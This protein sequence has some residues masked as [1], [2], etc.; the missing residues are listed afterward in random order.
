MRR[1]YKY[2]ILPNR[3]QAV[4][5]N[6]TVG[7][8]R[9]VYNLMLTDY[10]EQLNNGTKP[11]IKEVTAFKPQYPFLNEVDSLA[12]ANAKQNLHTAMKN[13][14][15]SKKGKRKGRKIGFPKIHKK[16]KSKLRYTTNNQNGTIRLEE[17]RLKLP[18][19]G[20]VDIVL[21]R[22]LEGKITSCS[23]EQTRDGKY[24]VSLLVECDD[25]CS[26]KNVRC[27]EV[28]RVVGIDMSLSC[29]A[30]D[31]TC[32]GNDDTKTKYVRLYRKHEKKL[33]RLH[34]RLSRKEKDS[35]NRNKARVKVARLNRHISNSRLDFCHKMSRHYADNFDVVMLEDIDLQSMSRSLHLGKSVMDMGFGMFRGFLSYKCMERDT[36]VLYCDRWY[37]S[38]KTCHSC[39]YL[40]KELTLSDRKWVCP[41]CGEVIDRD[42]NAALNIRDYFYKL[43]SPT[44]GTAGSNAF[45]DTASTLRET[46][47]QAV[48][49][50][51]EAPPFREG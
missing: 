1:A 28:L 25:R 45:G 10:K 6:K 2:R 41:N 18:K 21:H 7:C 26:V 14:F 44:A 31:S 23:V 3:E 43:I 5:I 24:F 34:R 30:I 50:N 13:F 16:S 36:L 8:A 9:L 42:V 15:D 27:L 12:L 47:M 37:A 38:S 4:L 33:A 32:E 22:P 17:G 35:S 48:S 19:I 39:G 11:K 29:F 49:S 40:N 46:L 20:F 51:K